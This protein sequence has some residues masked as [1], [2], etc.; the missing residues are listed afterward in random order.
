MLSKRAHVFYLE[1][2]RVLQK[3]DRVLYLTETGQE[4]ERFFNIPERNTVFLLL[5]KGTSITDSAIR[6]LAA[7]NVMVGFCGSS[8]SPL[9]SAVDWVF[10]EG[11][12]EY[13]PT[14]YMQSWAKMWFDDE[15]RL[16]TA[17]AFM[18]TRLEWTLASWE[19]NDALI[20]RHIQISDQM[21][22]QFEAKTA[23]AQNTLELLSA[24]GLWA[25][26]LYRV[27]AQGFDL[28]EDFTREEGKKSQV[29]QEDLVNGFLD[30]GN[31]IAYGYA[32]VVLH[33]LGINF[34]FPVLHGKTRRGGLVFDLADLIKDAYVMPTAF[35]YGT[36]PKKQKFFRGDLVS[37]MRDADVL[38]RLFGFVE[39]ASK[40]S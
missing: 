14:E 24:E 2:V 4:I 36:D 30:H 38:D 12:S 26:S 9:F 16:Q 17:K 22:R 31:Y 6:K 25:K 13:R 40:K 15:K 29:S 35:I 33:G 10:L 8:G 37:I 20:D 5:G 39:K 7:S 23:S 11:Q 1:H 28:S 3:D 27:L 34:A 18:K 32:A 21:I 19:D